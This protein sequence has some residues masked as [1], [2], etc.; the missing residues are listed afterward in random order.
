MPLNET[1]IRA[2]LEA[3]ASAE[4]AFRRAAIVVAASAN[5]TGTTFGIPRAADLPYPV[6]CHPARQVLVLERGVSDS[7]PIPSDVRSDKVLMDWFNRHGLLAS[8]GKSFV[9]ELRRID[10]LE[11]PNNSLALVFETLLDQRKGAALGMFSIGPTCMYLNL[12]PLAGP[13]YPRP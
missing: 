8:S 3:A 9:S 6:S 5:E 1:R 7:Q 12:S 10:T 2:A 4:I 11:N 13:Q